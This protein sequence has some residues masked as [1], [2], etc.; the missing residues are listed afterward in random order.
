VRNQP[1]PV[2]NPGELVLPR[3]IKSPWERFEDVLALPGEIRPGQPSRRVP[4]VLKPVT[5]TSTG[6][7]IPSAEPQHSKAGKFAETS[8]ITGVF[9]SFAL[10]APDP[11]PLENP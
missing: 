11:K 9:E 8:R 5:T 2:T 7:R 1:V 4:S 3:P 6:P 10:T